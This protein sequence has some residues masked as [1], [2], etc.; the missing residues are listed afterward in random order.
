ML[1]ERVTLALERCLGFAFAGETDLL[2]GDFFATGFLALFLA[3]D[4]DLPLEEVFFGV[5]TGA[6]ERAEL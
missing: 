2:L 6:S 1:C 5:F 3:G 4:F